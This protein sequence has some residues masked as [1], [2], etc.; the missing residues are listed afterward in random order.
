MAVKRLYLFRIK[1]AAL[2]TALDTLWA[3]GSVLGIAIPSGAELRVRA[4][5]NWGGEV[6]H[7]AAILVDL[8]Q[9]A[10]FDQ[11]LPGGDNYC[12]LRSAV[13][14][15]GADP[16]AVEIDPVDALLPALAS[17]SPTVAP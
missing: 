5:Q 4:N 16:W 15:D 6:Y 12:L 7:L 2:L 10:V 3:S 13:F 11:K 9:A 17:D 8:S 1:N 14:E